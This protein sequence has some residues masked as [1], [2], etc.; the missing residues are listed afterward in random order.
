MAQYSKRARTEKSKYAVIITVPD[1]GM[2]P[3]P[4]CSSSSNAFVLVSGLFDREK[5][6]QA[7]NDAAAVKEP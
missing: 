6:S 3:P 5:K 4:R 7:M 2:A 1:G